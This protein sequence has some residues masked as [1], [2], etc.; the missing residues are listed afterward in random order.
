MHVHSA[1]GRRVPDLSDP[2]RRRH[3]YCKEQSSGDRKAETEPSR[4]IRDE[5]TRTSPTH[6]G[7]ADREKSDD[8]DAL[9]LPVGL[10]TKGVEA[11]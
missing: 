7:H 11:L 2:K 4:Q 10:H 3:A 8:E 9:A 5:G 6:S 1:I